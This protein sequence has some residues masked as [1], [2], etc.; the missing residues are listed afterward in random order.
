MPDPVTAAADAA[1]PI[2]KPVGKAAKG[3]TGQPKWVYLVMAGGIVVVA[4]V[5]RQRSN[6]AAA[7]EDAAME[8]MVGAET[9]SMDPGYITPAGQTGA[10]YGDSQPYTGQQTPSAYGPGSG[11]FEQF[12][13][14]MLDSSFPD[15]YD[16]PTGGSPGSAPVHTAP[17]PVAVDNPTPPPPPPAPAPPPPPPAAPKPTC[18]ASHPFTDGSRGAP[19]WGCYRVV[20]KR[21]CHR[22]GANAWTVEERWHY[23]YNGQMHMV[24]ERKVRNG[25]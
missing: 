23:Y 21:V 8:P 20:L 6:A 16:P 4:Y 18:P 3:L 11:F 15:P 5:M 24:G 1:K 2:A 14:R 25:C 12:W 9:A 17:A 7:A 19:P 22:N 10:F 13:Q